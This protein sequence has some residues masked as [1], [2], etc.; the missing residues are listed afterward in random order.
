MTRMV[1][2]RPS[3]H[4]RSDAERR[5]FA[6][7]RDGLDGNWT[8]LHS[9]GLVSHHRQTWAEIDFVLVGPAGIICLEVKGG[10]ISRRAGVWWQ[11]SADGTEHPLKESPFEQVGSA[12]SALAGYLFE[13]IP[14]LRKSLIGFGVVVPDVPFRNSRPDIDLDLVYDAGDISTPFAVFL[15]RVVAWWRD[16]IAI[17]K[18][19]VPAGLE[20]LERTQTVELLRGDFDL[21]PSLRARLGL[22]AEDMLRLTTEQYNVLDGVA[23]NERAIVRGGAGTGKTLLA[24]EEARRCGPAGRVLLCCYNRNLADLLRRLVADRPNVVATSLHKWMFELV[25]S[26]GRQG[27]LPDAEEEDL[28]DVYY[29]ELALEAQLE[30]GGEGSF[31]TLIVDEGQDLMREPL[32]DVLDAALVGG[33][34]RGQ[35][36]IFYDG[37]QSLLRGSDPAGLS[38]LLG[39]APARYRLTVNCRNTAPIAIAT[40]LLSA[41]APQETSKLEGPDVEFVWYAEAEEGRRRLRHRLGQILYQGVKPSDIVILSTRGQDKSS[42]ARQLEGMT[43]PVRTTDGAITPAGTIRYSTIHA[44]KGLEADV[45]V[46]VDVVDLQSAEALDALYVGASRARALLVVLI[47][48]SLRPDFLDLSERFGERIGSMA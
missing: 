36:R 35:W 44:F 31:D 30:N 7:I 27:R 40:A 41:L 2:D 23:D 42:I 10:E 29:P 20:P 28:F 4:C 26:T 17:A 24:V 37:Q 12:S 18:G 3:E 8:C 38:R 15:D 14:G 25:G 21:R 1:P 34:R 47:P 19:K 39:F 32:L 16:R 33:L 13:V 22:V 48:E 9:L 46:L 5:T 43:A 45:V 6:R 11:R